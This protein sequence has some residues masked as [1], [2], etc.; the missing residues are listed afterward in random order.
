VTN[1]TSEAW[2]YCGIYEPCYGHV[3]LRLWGNTWN[4]AAGGAAV[5]AFHCP[6][7]KMSGMLIAR[8]KSF[9]A[10]I[11]AVQACPGGLGR[12]SLSSVKTDCF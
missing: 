1:T 7:A 4:D 12:A 3:L 5:P 8:D 10:D 6:A 2:R 11:Q 9:D